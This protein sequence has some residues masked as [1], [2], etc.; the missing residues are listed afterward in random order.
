MQTLS[1]GMIGC[2]TVG[3][4][5]L[6]I[7]HRQKPQFEALGFQVELTGVLVRDA[8]KPRETCFPNAPLVTSK[9]FLK[10]VDVVIEVMGGVQRPLDLVLPALQAGK[11]VITAN[12]AML[13]ERWNELKPYA[14]TGQLYYEA[15]VMAGTPVID[16]LSGILRSSQPIALQAILNGT[17]NYILTQMEKG[18]GYQEALKEAQ[19]LGYAEA[20]PTLDVGGFDAA[21]KLTV[22]ARL[23]FDPDYP[24]ADVSIRGIDTIPQEAVKNALDNNQ[25]IRLI[26]SIYAEDG[27]WKAKV[28]PRVLPMDHP[29]ARAAS[30]RNA[31]VFLGDECGEIFVAGGGA[32]GAVTASGVVGDLINHLQGILGPK[33]I[34]LAAQ[35]PAAGFEDLPEV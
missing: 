7:L 2:G 16:P 15:A 26:G 31:M 29:I 24:Y 13:A 22:L 8:S 20:D 11:V 14:S 5:V 1:I 21:H 19:D 23:A 6:D 30:G 35:V 4:G 25:R 9:D 27:K 17:C 10:D 32:G 34:A 33:P 12:K 28:A 3:T 18:K